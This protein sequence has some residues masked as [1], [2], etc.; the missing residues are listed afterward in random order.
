M[1]FEPA[2]IDFH[3]VLSNVEQFAARSSENKSHDW[4]TNGYADD[5]Q[6]FLA[7][8]LASRGC[9][10]AGVLELPER[11]NVRSYD[12]S[13]DF[14]MNSMR[15]WLGKTF[16]KYIHQT[17]TFV[18]LTLHKP[19]FAVEGTKRILDLHEDGALV[20]DAVCRSMNAYEAVFRRFPQV[21]EFSRVTES[22]LKKRGSRR[23]KVEY[24]G[25]DYIDTFVKNDQATNLRAWRSSNCKALGQGR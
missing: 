20:T 25:P 3:C 5:D 11:F 2:K 9:G 10:T 4:Y 7:V 21:L 22:A 19:F 6:R 16:P 17:A 15:G 18:H 8:S 1:V 14:N 24:L 12:Y 23:T 13:G